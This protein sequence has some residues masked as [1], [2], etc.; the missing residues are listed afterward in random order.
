MVDSLHH[1]TTSLCQVNAEFRCHATFTATTNTLCHA[2]QPVLEWKQSL[3]VCVL[4]R[5][6]PC[7]SGNHPLR[8]RSE[9]VR[10][11]KC[12]YET[13]NFCLQF[14]R[15]KI[16]SAN[17]IEAVCCNSHVQKNKQFCFSTRQN[18]I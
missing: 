1:V 6:E 14:L 16:M 2:K 15:Q 17:N 12:K 18:H 3:F 10:M 4:N 5:A 8:A 7:P 13:Y 9:A 11:I